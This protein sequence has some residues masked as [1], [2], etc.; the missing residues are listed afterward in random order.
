[1]SGA[2]HPV[3]PIPPPAADGQSRNLH[4]RTKGEMQSA[5]KQ[6]GL[7]HLVIARPLGAADV[8]WSLGTLPSSSGAYKAGKL[9]YAAVAAD[10]RLPQV[11]EVPTARESGGPG[12]RVDRV[13]ALAGAD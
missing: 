2:G 1:M 11:P 8:A 7:R 6:V 12:V 13:A 4:N 10:K 3:G 5:L 9:R